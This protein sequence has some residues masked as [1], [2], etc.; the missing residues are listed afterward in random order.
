MAV[1]ERCLQWSLG[2]LLILALS[3]S[4]GAEEPPLVPARVALVVVGHGDEDPMLGARIESLFGPATRVRLRAQPRLTAAEVLEPEPG[5]AVHVWIAVDSHGHAR[6]YLATRQGEAGDA[7]YLLREVTLESGL[8]EVGAETVAQIAHSSVMALWSRRSETS[9]E[10]VAV[11]LA[12]EGPEAAPP[13]APAAGARSE[14]ATSGSEVAT[15]RS[16]APTIGSAPPPAS[17]PRPPVPTTEPRT[18]SSWAPA[19]GVR[20]AAHHSGGEGFLFAPG[21]FVGLLLRDRWGLRLAAE[22]SVPT[23]FQT[24]LARIHLEGGNVEARL[25]GRFAELG[26]LGLRLEV[27]GGIRFVRWDASEV[28]GT[29]GVGDYAAESEH[30]GHGVVGLAVE[31][32]CGSLRAGLGAELR[33][34][35]ATTRYLVVN[36]G[37]GLVIAEAGLAPG[38]ALELEGPAP[39]RARGEAVR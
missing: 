7:R 26:P 11:E 21:V 33:V 17:S 24:P 4:A 2:G 15:P 30:R 18:R 10:A 31:I 23:S 13:P 6:I 8:D 38:F 9:R 14:V 37:T 39:N 32:P 22:Y 36:N 34:P 3:A 12:R 20:G 19:L 28:A 1:A 35:T 29:E 5:D 25:T 27:G 16:E